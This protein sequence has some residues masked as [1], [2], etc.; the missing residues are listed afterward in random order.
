MTRLS[1]M[2][3]VDFIFYA[4]L[5]FFKEIFATIWKSSVSLQKSCTEPMIEAFV[6][7]VFDLGAFWYYTVHYL[8]CNIT[9]RP[10]TSA[11][12]TRAL[13][14]DFPKYKLTWS[15]KNTFILCYLRR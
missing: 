14:F 15:L 4:L 6:I 7:F 12:L 5:I 10:K 1:S 8:R 13:W 11:A 2:L 9:K 3:S